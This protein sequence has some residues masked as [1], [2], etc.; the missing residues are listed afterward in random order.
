MQVNEVLA[1]M[2]KKQYTLAELQTR[3]LPDGVDE[4]KLE[5]YLTDEE[6]KVSRFILN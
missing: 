5:S 1:N 4:L 6:F 2:M 3:P